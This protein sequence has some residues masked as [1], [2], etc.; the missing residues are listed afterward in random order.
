M[1]CSKCGAENP[2]GNRFCGSCG[3]TLA[4][5]GRPEGS[6]CASCGAALAEGVSHCGQCG[7]PV[8]SAAGPASSSASVATPPAVQPGPG[9]VEGTLAP[10][11]RS[12]NREPTGLAAAGVVFV[13]GA[14]VSL[15][16]WWPLG[17]PARTIN[18][19]VPQGNCVGV[20]PGSF[21]MYVCSMKVAAL[22]VFGPVGLMVLLIVMRQTVT[23]WLKTLMPRLH[24]EARFLVGPVAA[25][26]LFTMAWA[27]VH[28]AAPGR[29]GLLPQNVFPA[30]VG[31]FT[32]A[33]GR[34]GPA[35]QRA[36]GAFFDF[37]D[38]FPRWMRFVAAMLVP[39]A[40]SLIITYQQR[41]S[42]ETLKE[43]VIV[44]VAL[45]TSYLALAPRAG[46][47]LAGVREMVKKRQGGG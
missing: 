26:A 21:A 8:G 36:L 3:A 5:G 27:G 6:T 44:L 19:F 4:P 22:S 29:S 15:L 9:F 1:R 47:L 45:A 32:F 18:A 25:T 30:V 24:T 11:L 20:V 7:A 39:L 33:V 37:R 13:V 12:V 35:V 38:R 16:G 42:Q 34:Y 41:V 2:S 43:Q 17:L 10:F 46:D 28:D 14:L 31:L 23:A 40:L